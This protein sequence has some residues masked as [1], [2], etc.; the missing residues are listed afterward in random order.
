[1]TYD[2]LIAFY[3]RHKSWKIV[4]SL[5]NLDIYKVN[6]IRNEYFV[7]QIKDGVPMKLIALNNKRNY[8][9]ILRERNIYITRQLFNG[10]SKKEIAR[11]LK[12]DIDRVEDACYSYIKR[13]IHERK[14]ST[15]TFYRLSDLMDV[16]REFIFERY[17]IGSLK[18]N[19]GLDELSKI[20]NLEKDKINNIRKNYVIKKI[21]LGFP[22]ASFIAE[23]KINLKDFP[24]VR[25]ACVVYELK[26]NQIF[27]NFSLEKSVPNELSPNNPKE[28][29]LIKKFGISIE[30]MKEI[31]SK[32]IEKEQQNGKSLITIAQEF[33]FTVNER[34][35]FV[36]DETVKTRVE[37]S[38]KEEL[39]VVFANTSKYMNNPY[40]RTA[41]T[42]MQVLSK[43]VDLK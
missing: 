37:S 21:E 10:I 33:G 32:Y 13:E 23:M 25:D 4:R 17:I 36:Y 40:K 9:A 28:E 3:N 34:G 2:K 6:K 39:A 1:M 41:E 15:D 8:H 30:G 16:S 12:M 31:L 29:I 19:K 18:K 43:K 26:K 14:I 11:Q 20:L 35:K 22:L 38:S 24:E 42:D 7:K 27:T 5:F